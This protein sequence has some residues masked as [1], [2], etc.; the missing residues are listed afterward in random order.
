MCYVSFRVGDSTWLS[1]CINDKVWNINLFV[2][3][4]QPEKTT[5][6]PYIITTSPGTPKLSVVWACGHRRFQAQEVED[7][8]G[9]LRGEDV[10]M[11][12]K[13]KFQ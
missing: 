9:R 5:T 13:D 11:Q 10:V 12:S 8:L 4:S 3:Q 2:S 1:T 7:Q 6:I